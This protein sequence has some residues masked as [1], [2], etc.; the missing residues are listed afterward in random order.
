MK[1]D[2]EI[3][4][5]E[6]IDTLKYFGL[7]EYESRI[8]ATLLYSA[9]LTATQLSFISKVPR[10]KVYGAIKKLVE[11]GLVVILPEKPEKYKAVSP[12]TFYPILNKQIEQIKNMNHIIKDLEK[13]YKEKERLESEERSILVI[14]GRENIYQKIREMSEKMKKE[15]LLITTSNGLVRTYRGFKDLIYEKRHS[16]VIFRI[17]APINQVN[18]EYVKKLISIVPSKIKIRHT[19]KCGKMRVFIVDDKEMVLFEAVPD[20]LSTESASDIGIWTNCSAFI[21]LMKRCF[22]MIW[23]NSLDARKITRKIE[24]KMKSGRAIARLL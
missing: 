3:S 1:N 11:K 21:D 24:K 16:G 20:N 12:I 10:P 22:G 9:P 6:V 15:V 19:D 18:Y 2:I 17:I 23:S 5:H 13:R 14:K 7:T 4:E 8:Y